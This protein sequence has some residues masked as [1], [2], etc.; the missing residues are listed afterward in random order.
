MTSSNPKHTTTNVANTLRFLNSMF[1][2]LFFL[3][4]AKGLSGADLLLTGPAPGEGGAKDDLLLLRLLE[5]W[6]DKY[7]KSPTPKHPRVGLLCSVLSWMELADPLLVWRASR[8]TLSWDVSWR[9]AELAL[10][11]CSW[12]VL[13]FLTLQAMVCVFCVFRRCLNG[14]T[15]MRWINKCWEWNWKLRGLWWS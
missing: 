5:F 6:A 3:S 4:K 9:K 13:M 14:D 1:S 11:L 15:C 7:F 10:L 2:L 12:L 8:G